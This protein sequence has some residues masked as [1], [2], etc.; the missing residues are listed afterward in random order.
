ML[1]PLLLHSIHSPL[2]CCWKGSLDNTWQRHGSDLSLRH[3][4]YLVNWDMNLH[5]TAAKYQ[6]Q[7]AYA[8]MTFTLLQKGHFLQNSLHQSVF[9]TGKPIPVWVW[10][11]ASSLLVSW[12]HQLVSGW[13]WQVSLLWKALHIWQLVWWFSGQGEWM[14]NQG[15]DAWL[16]IKCQN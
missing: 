5:T 2:S 11:Q 15:L 8:P 13:H 6:A 7:Q 14:L 3:K 9:N 12:L 4:H 16:E 10:P 1:S